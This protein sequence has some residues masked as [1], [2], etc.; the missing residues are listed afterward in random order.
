[1]GQAPAAP[2]PLLLRIRAAISRGTGTGGCL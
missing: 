2:V 1:M